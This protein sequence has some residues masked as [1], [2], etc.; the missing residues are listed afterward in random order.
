MFPAAEARRHCGRPPSLSQRMSLSGDVSDSHPACASV[1]SSKVRAILDAMEILASAT[2][3]WRCTFIAKVSLVI[4]GVLGTSAEVAMTGSASFCCDNCLSD[5]DLTILPAR[6]SGNGLAAGTVDAGVSARVLASVVSALAQELGGHAHVDATKIYSFGGHRPKAYPVLSVYPASGYS[7]LPALDL[8]YG[9]Y[10]AT[11][12]S[13]WVNKEVW[14]ECGRNTTGNSTRVWPPETRLEFMKLV[15]LWT[16]RRKLPTRS[17]GGTPSVAWTVMSV[18]VW[19][20]L[21]PSPRPVE[22]IGPPQASSTSASSTS[23]SSRLES[24]ESSAGLLSAFFKLYL[25]G[26]TVEV[27]SKSEE[28]SAANSVA[29]DS[30][31]ELPPSGFLGGTLFASCDTGSLVFRPNPENARVRHGLRVHSPLSVSAETVTGDVAEGASTVREPERRWRRRSRA[32]SS[33]WAAVPPLLTS[34]RRGGAEAATDLLTDELSEATQLAL[35][36]EFARALAATESGDADRIF[37]GTEAFCSPPVLGDVACFLTGGRLYL[38]VIVEM[39][40]PFFC[41]SPRGNAAKTSGFLGQLVSLEARKLLISG[42][43]TLRFLGEEYVC[44][45][46]FEDAARGRCPPGDQHV[47]PKDW[48][49]QGNGYFPGG[50]FFATH[51][52]SRPTDATAQAGDDLAPFT[53]QS[54]LTQSS[55]ECISWLNR[56]TL[57]FQ[58][59]NRRR[60]S[61]ASTFGR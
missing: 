2:F 46:F 42:G 27:A 3:Y 59:G 34:P 26:Y 50:N 4:R 38:A 13:R 55:S 33:G 61:A 11:A 30:G 21:L 15:K 25:R 56:E 12:F 35:S 41:R 23:F 52:L 58:R 32:G 6:V 51:H 16:K 7:F 47:Y 18:Y 22:P 17:E 24:A 54:S 48:Q 5:V 10:A 36:F 19:Q 44:R 40:S 14:A 60:D 29:P 1:L 39:Q 49:R 31:Q 45:L 28:A 53:R 9:S 57:R 37:E 8:T 20:V 43:R